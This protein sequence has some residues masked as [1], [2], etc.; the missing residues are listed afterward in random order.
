MN[1]KLLIKRSKLDL[2]QEYIWTNTMIMQ[3]FGVGESKASE[4]RKKAITEFN[5]T[6][7]IDLKKVK[8][9]SVLLTTGTSFEKELSTLERIAKLK[10]EQ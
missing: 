3:Y 9:D 2:L 5:G 10:H 7:L 8:R 6:F 4:I 1:K